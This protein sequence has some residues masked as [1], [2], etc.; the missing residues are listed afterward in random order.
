MYRVKDLLLMHFDVQ[1]IFVT[2]TTSLMLFAI[3]TSCFMTWMQYSHPRLC[4]KD[5][6]TT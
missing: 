2:Q 3:F 1:L 6:W 4:H 5:Y